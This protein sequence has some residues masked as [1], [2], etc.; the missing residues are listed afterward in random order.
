M[1]KFIYG[2][3]TT[4]VSTH[5]TQHSNEISNIIKYKCSKKKSSGTSKKK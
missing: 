4:V 1:S 2:I 3:S 5:D